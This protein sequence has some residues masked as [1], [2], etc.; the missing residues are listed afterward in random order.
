MLLKK[1]LVNLMLYSN[2]KI[3]KI[4]NKN[5]HIINHNIKLFKL[6]EK[7]YIP[8]NL[9]DRY[10]PLQNIKTIQLNKKPLGVGFQYIYKKNA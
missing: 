5:L 9:P 8:A 7:E 4:T 6:L 1:D 3:K 2:I 10:T